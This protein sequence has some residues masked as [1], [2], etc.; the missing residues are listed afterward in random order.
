MECWLINN[1]GSHL[2]CFKE[3]L[4]L[5]SW[6][7]LVKCVFPLT[8][9][10]PPYCSH[11]VSIAAAAV[12]FLKG[13]SLSFFP[14]R[15]GTSAGASDCNLT[16]WIRCPI[17]MSAMTGGARVRQFNSYPS[18]QSFW[19]PALKPGFI[20]WIRCRI[21]VSAMTGGQSTPI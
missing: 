12:I 6:G 3:P 18:L 9:F 5:G 8:S 16:D 11:N 10:P 19:R 1:E 7:N 20:N 13:L 4:K 17:L 21:L 2:K 15:R 14:H